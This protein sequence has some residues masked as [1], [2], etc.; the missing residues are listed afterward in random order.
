MHVYGFVAHAC[1]RGCSVLRQA[2]CVPRSPWGTARRSARLALPLALAASLSTRRSSARCPSGFARPSTSGSP[3]GAAAAAQCIRAC[4]RGTCR[5]AG[6]LKTGSVCSR[7]SSPRLRAPVR[8]ESGTAGPLLAP[9]GAGGRSGE[10]YAEKSKE[11]AGKDDVE[12]KIDELDEEKKRDGDTETT[13][14]RCTGW[15]ASSQMWPFPGDVMDFAENPIVWEPYRAP[16]YLLELKKKRNLF[17]LHLAVSS[18]WTPTRL[19]S[20]QPLRDAG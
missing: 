17:E 14:R 4:E 11:K 3:R 19:P 5:A 20:P 6:A 1:I 2:A 13:T 7:G 15:T 9:E 10:L 18:S 8:R 16:Y 12:P